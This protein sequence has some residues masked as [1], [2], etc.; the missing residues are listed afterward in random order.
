VHPEV[1]ATQ[2]PHFSIPSNSRIS[3][4]SWAYCATLSGSIRTPRPGRTA[5]AQRLQGLSL[6]GVADLVAQQ[7]AQQGLVLDVRQHTGG[8]VEPSI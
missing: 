4:A 1:T 3:F 7:D 8:E 5:P 2:Q 6:N